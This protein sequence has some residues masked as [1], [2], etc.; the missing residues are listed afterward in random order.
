MNSLDGLKSLRIQNHSNIILS[1]LNIK[2]IRNKFDDLKLIVNE[3]LDILCI[4]E[5]KIDESFPT[6]QFLLPGYHKPYRLDISD[7]QGGLLIYIKAHLPSKLLS[8]HISPKDIQAVPTELNLR[9]EKWM[10]VCIYRPPKQDS[11]YFLGNLSL[12][13]DHYSSICDNHIILGDFNMEP[14][15]PKLA[16]FMHSFNLNNLI[17][18]NTCLKGSGSCIDPILTNRKYCFK[19]TSTFETGLSDH[20]HLIYSILKT[21]FKKEESKKFIFRDYKNF[22]NTNF[23]MDFESKLNNC[24]KKY[25][26][27]EKAFE[28]VLNAHAP[29]KIKF[30]RGNQKPHVDKNLSKAIMKR[31]QLKNK[32]NRT[33]NLEDITK[34]KKQRN[35]V[36][37]LNRESKTQYFDN[38]QT[39]KNSKPFWD[40]CKPY[41][42]N[43]H[44]HG[45]SKIILIEKEN[46]IINKN[47]VV[48]KEILLVNNDEI[49]KA[50]NN[51]FSETVEKLN[52]FKWPFNEK[53][54]NIHN[55]KLTTI[56]KKFENHPSIMKIKSKYTMQE[57]F[58]VKPVTVEDVEN[59]IKNIPKNKASG[60]EIPL[61]ILK[62]SRFTYEI[63]TDCITDAIVGENI[64]PDRL[65]FADITPVHKKDE[66]TNK[67][68]YGP[69]SV[70]PLISKI[71]E[72]IIYD[73]LS[74]YLEK[75]LN[76]ILCGFRKAHCTHNMLYLSY[77]KH[78]RKN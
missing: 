11:Q 12:I 19:H 33:K 18:S 40:K 16:S 10:S 48:R 58:S 70:L 20:H 9:K 45:D 72:R 25:G 74:E 30:L 24:P 15:N 29:K 62:Q 55:E 78:G 59:I 61:N 75:Y 66:T 50:L 52:T 38:I 13:I 39:T 65:K 14:K 51:H 49:A 68:N 37:K 41:F 60:G 46:I 56:I 36:V 71:F 69:V 67:E 43:K 17:K 47:E 34:Y 57:M 22:D 28:N 44:A 3:Y 2:S 64:F 6:A 8:N 4:A 32:A 26:I 21:T 53:Y 63:L 27:F 42:S 73:Q 23:Q 1:Y 54:E 7:K 76:S 35:L 5:T 31:S 77:Y